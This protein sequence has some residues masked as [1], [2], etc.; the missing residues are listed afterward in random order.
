MATGLVELEIDRWSGRWGFSVL[1][2]RDEMIER[3]RHDL[4]RKATSL[5]G[6]CS[7]GLA[8][9]AS[10]GSAAAGADTGEGPPR[11]PGVKPEAIGLPSRA[12]SLTR[13]AMNCVST[14]ESPATSTRAEIVGV[15]L[16]RGSLADDDVG[17]GFSFQTLI[18][19]SVRILPPPP[20]RITA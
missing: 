20:C 5:C 11:S 17:L 10:C 9:P 12:T 1:H 15:R 18:F 6:G 7:H 2:P 16:T 4:D 8:P 3:R 13:L 19:R 14:C